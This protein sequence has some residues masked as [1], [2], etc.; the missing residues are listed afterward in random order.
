MNNHDATEQAYKNGFEAGYNTAKDEIFEKLIVKNT[1]E[2][3]AI[4]K[5]ETK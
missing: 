4:L 2:I 1:K 3:I 5:D